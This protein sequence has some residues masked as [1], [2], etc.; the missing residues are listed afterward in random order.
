M[1]SSQRRRWAQR[2]A[3]TGRGEHAH[4]VE[5]MGGDPRVDGITPQHV[6]DRRISLREKKS[7]QCPNEHGAK[8]PVVRDL[9]VRLAGGEEL[10]DWECSCPSDR[11]RWNGAR[12]VEDC[13]SEA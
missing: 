6:V 12:N 13:P 11:Y 1:D 4:A 9:L 3:E 10:P 5:G 2:A 8:C 7:S